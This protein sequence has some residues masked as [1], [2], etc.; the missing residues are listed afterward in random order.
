V[1]LD[2]DLDLNIALEKFHRLR[3]E[4]GD[5]GAAYWYQI[6]KLPRK[7]HLWQQRTLTTEEKLRRIHTLSK[8]T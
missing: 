2:S 1:T 5:L 4:E 7:A 8:I 3:L 6:S